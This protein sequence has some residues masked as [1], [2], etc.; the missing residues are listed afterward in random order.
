VGEG[1]IIMAD[2]GSRCIVSAGA[3]VIKP[4]PDAS[5]LGGNPAR[6]LARPDAASDC[7]AVS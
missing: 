5:V 1:A 4:A 3:V 6:V 2:V 7:V